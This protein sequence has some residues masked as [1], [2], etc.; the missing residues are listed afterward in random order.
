MT[1]PVAPPAVFAAMSTVGCTPMAFAV[2]TCSCANSVLLLTTEPVMNT[3]NHPM[4]GATSGKSGPMAAS[5]DP[6]VAEPPE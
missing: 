5:A 3:P 6:I 4:I 2:V 1:F